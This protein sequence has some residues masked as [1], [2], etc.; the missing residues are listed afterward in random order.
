MDEE[1]WAYHDFNVIVRNMNYLYMYLSTS[2]TN[3]TLISF[4]IDK[5]FH[6]SNLIGKKIPKKGLFHHLKKTKKGNLSYL[7]TRMWRLNMS[8]L[9]I[10]TLP[11]YYYYFNVPYIE[12]APSISI[13]NQMI[14]IDVYSIFTCH[15]NTSHF[16]LLF[17]LQSSYT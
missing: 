16:F 13:V 2:F 7:R 17:F 11:Y 15:S 8:F 10:Y 9:D 3:I 14:S 12:I 6:L 5:K 1:T 4:Y